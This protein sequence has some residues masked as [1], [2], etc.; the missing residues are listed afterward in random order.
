V[1]KETTRT[2]FKKLCV[3]ETL[4]AE[5]TEP[6]CFVHSAVPEPGDPPSETAKAILL[7]AGD[8]VR[9]KSER[10]RLRKRSGKQLAH[11]HRP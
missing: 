3:T 5:A 4:V 2:L 6:S 7:K 1:N 10:L 9:K 8:G 11:K